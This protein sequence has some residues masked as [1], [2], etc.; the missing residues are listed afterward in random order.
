VSEY[1]VVIEGEAASGFVSEINTVD[2]PVMGL[3][4]EPLGAM[5]LPDGTTCL[6][7]YLPRAAWGA[8][9]GLR[10]IGGTEVWP[11]EYTPTQ[12]LT[13]H[14][15]A[16]ANSDPDPAGTVRAIYYYQAVTQAWGD[17]G[18]HVL[19]DE[20]GRVYE[21]RWSGP[22]PVCV[23]NNAV[24]AGTRPGVVTAG[25]VAATT[26]VTSASACSAI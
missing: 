12:T 9:E 5:P 8:D 23:F 4:A 6:V 22:D 24:P 19:I 26:P 3:A 13:V 20:H 16:G 11:T 1:D 10:F 15:T 2:G 25:H 14:H 7:T 18:Y 21:G 17:I